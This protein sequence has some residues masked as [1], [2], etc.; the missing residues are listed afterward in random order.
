MSK[1]AENAARVRKLEN[2][3]PQEQAVRV[4]WDYGDIVEIDGVQMT[5]AEYEKQQEPGTLVIEWEPD[6]SISSRRIKPARAGG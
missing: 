2:A 6:G 5:R 4:V 3:K 1:N